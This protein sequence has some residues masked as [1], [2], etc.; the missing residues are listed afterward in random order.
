MGSWKMED[1][2]EKAKLREKAKA[3]YEKV[4]MV[5]NE[6]QKIRLILN[7]ITPDNYDKKFAELRG[8]LF[9]NLRS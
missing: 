5:K 1:T 4:T 3:M 9:S 8:F 6:E 2:A 7:V